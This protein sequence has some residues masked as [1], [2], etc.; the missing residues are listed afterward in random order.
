MIKGGKNN[1]S[2]QPIFQQQNVINSIMSF[3]PDN[4]PIT[5]LQ[6]VEDYEKC[7]KH[8][9]AVNRTYDQDSDADLWRENIL[10]GRQT[11]RYLCYSKTEGLPEYVLETLKIISEKE[12]PPQEFSL[13]SR[14][15]DTEQ[16]AW[17]KRQIAYK[18]SKRGNVNYAITDIIL[19][20]KLKTA[21]DGFKF[22]GEINGILVC[23]KTGTL[24]VR[25]SPPVPLV[26]HT[27]TNSTASEVEKALNRINLNSKR[28]SQPLPPVP[29]TE[30]DYEEISASFQLSPKRPAPKP[31]SSSTNNINNA[32]SHY[33]PIGTLG[34][35]TEIE[36]VPFTLHPNLAKN[37]NS[38]GACINE[39][40]DK[41][42]KVN[43][44]NEDLEYDFQL[45]RQILCTMK[46]SSS[47]N[48]FFK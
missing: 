19:C 9:I 37:S 41:L 29:T 38:N 32:V 14:T 40:M 47:T 42:T 23:Y 28:L 35:Y 16:K 13:L 5:S 30:H 10:F 2:S 39:I 11:S 36:G 3:L 31:P 12:T 21:P 34:T 7:P 4:R 1:V 8:F 44:K 15:A 43:K 48:P 24:P 46:S 17:R 18:L 26:S 6:I 20:S 22:A 25:Q 45:E 33:T 27:N